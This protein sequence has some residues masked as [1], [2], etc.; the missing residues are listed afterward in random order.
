[1]IYS[2][3]FVL[4]WLDYHIKV[5][6][7]WIELNN[8]RL[9]RMEMEKLLVWPPTLRL[10]RITN[11]L[12]KSMVESRME[13][14]WSL[15]TR[16]K[17]ALPRDNRVSRDKTVVAWRLIDLSPGDRSLFCLFPFYIFCFAEKTW[18]NH[19]EDPT[20]YHQLQ[21]TM[22]NRERRRQKDPR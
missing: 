7:F 18:E 6:I 15:G 16:G 10:S 8:C 11:Q 14:A 2:W 5:E 21:Q 1:M 13:L 4:E 20:Q 19:L 3:S 9:R 17:R 22:I 12:M